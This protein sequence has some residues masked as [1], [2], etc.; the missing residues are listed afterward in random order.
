M[1]WLSKILRRSNAEGPTPNPKPFIHKIQC[2]AEL[3]SEDNF[4][5]TE[6]LCDAFHLKGHFTFH[7]IAEFVR[8]TRRDYPEATLLAT[9]DDPWQAAYTSSHAKM[10]L[11][12]DALEGHSLSDIPASAY[13]V[14]DDGEEYFKGYFPIR[15]KNFMELVKKQPEAEFLLEGYFSD[16]DHPVFFTQEG[17]HKHDR[18]EQSLVQIVPVGFS[19]EAL[20]AFPN[21]YFRDDN[22][23]IENYKLAKSLSPLGLSLF[24]IGAR[25]LGFMA[26]RPFDDV[27]AD[28]LANFMAILEE[29]NGLKPDRKKLEESL[30]GQ[31]EIYIAYGPA[32]YMT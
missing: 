32:N 14:F 8:T 27:S 16:Q 25:Y 30:V 2:D 28:R 10:S 18:I 5:G 11:N 21:G 3:F 6:I 17:I 7:E 1:G 19:P 15:H 29:K 22:G 23:P 4:C 9:L 12:L 20:C 26:E 24:G 13:E 31:S